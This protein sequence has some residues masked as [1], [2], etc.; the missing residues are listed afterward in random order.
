MGY[1]ENIRIVKELFSN[2]VLLKNLALN[3]GGLYIFVILLFAT[4]LWL[5]YPDKRKVYMNL[6]IVPYYLFGIYITYITEVRV[7]TELIPMITTLFLIFLSSFKF[8]G[9]EPWALNQK[10]QA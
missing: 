4:G 7:Y 3:F 9:L 10:K 5:K 2:R 6:A 8:S 1:Y